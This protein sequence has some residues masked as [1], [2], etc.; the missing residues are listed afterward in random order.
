[1]NTSLSEAEWTLWYEDTFDRACPR[2]IEMTGRGL[3]QGLIELWARYLFETVRPD[4]RL[5]FSRFNLW[6]KQAGQS[7]EVLGSGQGAARLR[8]WIFGDERSTDN[9]Y[10]Q[11]GDT[12]FLYKLAKLHARLILFDRTSETILE[13]AGMAKNRADFE[14]WLQRRL[15]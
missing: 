7:I 15:D 3:V 12:D 8:D 6:W 2:Q 5:G 13:A 9:G 11:A 4:G 1:M 14:R 10:V